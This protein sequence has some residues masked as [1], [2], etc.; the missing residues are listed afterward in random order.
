M[1]LALAEVNGQLCTGLKAVLADV[2]TADVECP[3]R[4]EATDLGDAATLIIDGQAL[5]IAI[6]IPKTAS[7][8]GDFADVFI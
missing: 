2:L 8:F 4:V 5:V 6:G 7:T 3:D 1:P